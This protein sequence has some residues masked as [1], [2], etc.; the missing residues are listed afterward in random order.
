[1][2][3][4]FIAIAFILPATPVFAAIHDVEAASYREH[5]TFICYMLGT[6][7]TLEDWDEA[8]ASHDNI[9]Q[10]ARDDGASVKYMEAMRHAGIARAESV[11]EEWVDHSDALLICNDVQSS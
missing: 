8:T 11:M 5:L 3:N 4:F 10:H 2:R 1:M 7:V 6:S 9:A